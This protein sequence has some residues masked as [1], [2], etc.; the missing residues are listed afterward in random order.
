MARTT[1][2]VQIGALRFR[3]GPR[4]RTIHVGNN[5]WWRWLAADGNTTFRFECSGASYTARREGG[6]WYAYRKQGGRLV[7]AYLGKSVDL[8]LARLETVAFTLAERATLADG[9]HPAQQAADS[10]KTAPRRGPAPISHPRPRHQHPDGHNLPGGLTSFVGRQRQ[11]ADLT[12]VLETARLVS[13]TGPGGVGKT[14][15]ALGVASAL[16]SEYRGVWFVELAPLADPELVS[17]TVA[18]V[19]GVREGRGRPL[20]ATLVE[21]I[22][23]ERVLLV[24]DNCEHVLEASATLLAALLGACPRLSVLTTSREVLRIPGELVREVPALAVPE[25]PLPPLERLGDYAAVQLFVERARAVRPDFALTAQNARAVVVICQRLD[26][27]PLAIELAAAWA[28]VLG[29]EQLV[30]RLDDRFRLLVRPSARGLPARQQTL[31]GVIDWSYALLPPEEQALFNRLSVFAGSFDLESAEAVCGGEDLAS[32]DIL[33]LLARLVDKSLVATE[34]LAASGS[35]RYRLLEILRAYALDRVREAGEVDWL[36]QRHRDRYLALA[37]QRPPEMLAPDH[38]D[39]LARELDNL[40][41]ALRR[42]IASCDVETGLRLGVALWPLW[43]VRGLYAEGRASLSEILALPAVAPLIRLRSRALAWAGHLAFCQG[44]YAA[45]EQ[46]LNQA[47]EMSRGLGDDQEVAVALQLLGTPAR[48]RGDLAHAEQLYEQA[49]AINRRL[50]SRVWEAMTL[51]NLAMSAEDRADHARAEVVAGEAL[52]LYAEQGHP[53]GVAR[54]REVLARVAVSRADFT[55]AREQ[56]EEAVAFQR[57]LGDRQGLVMSLP[58]LARIAHGLG[59]PGH[60][61]D[62]LAEGLVLAH[63]A[64]E[65]LSVARALEAIATLLAEARPECSMRLVGAASALRQELGARPTPA[66]RDRLDRWQ[67]AAL[68][69]LGGHAYAAALAEGSQQ[70]LGQVVAE[71]AAGAQA[72]VQRRYA[73]AQRGDELTPRER[74]VARLLASGLSNRQIGEAL[75]IAEGTARIH[76]ERILAKLGLRSRVQ[77]AAW[78]RAHLLS[79][80]PAD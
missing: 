46:L 4:D 32:E 35:V 80:E 61:G 31:R 76:A 7:K 9:M 64:G 8:E 59:E 19:L 25:Q 67:A 52:A 22:G 34:Q 18:G 10:P 36:E 15:L 12:Q 56:L 60:A 69:L 24:L 30:Q 11:L 37:E 53:W 33:P 26:G 38:I 50:A 68:R 5:A 3:D 73:T 77:V 63:E 28:R 55:A 57:E 62:L 20:L 41:G 47:L 65:R 39:C 27:L 14:R 1:P 78:A 66:E 75:T 58:T 51:G 43:Y 74:E 21:R 79:T 71:A 13:L 44:D 70:S 6:Y 17:Q 45:A 54:M 40:R 48:G 29:P 16:L 49:C 23:V 42:A 2:K 72:V